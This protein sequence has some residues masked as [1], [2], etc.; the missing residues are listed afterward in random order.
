[1]RELSVL[2]DYLLGKSGDDEEALA[3]LRA[4]S[5]EVERLQ[6]AERTLASLGGPTVYAATIRN[7][8]GRQTSGRIRADLIR[9]QYSL[10]PVVSR[11][12]ERGLPAPIPGLEF[13]KTEP[14]EVLHN[15]VWRRGEVRLSPGHVVIVWMFP[16]EGEL[17]GGDMLTVFDPEKIRRPQA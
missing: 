16:P 5:E 9:A 12:I 13:I 10:G 7:A 6:R 2:Q 11:S 17:F 15:D 4:V 8:F 14:V 3:A 1:M